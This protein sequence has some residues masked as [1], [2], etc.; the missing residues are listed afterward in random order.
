MTTTAD[1]PTTTARY[2]YISAGLLGVVVFLFGFGA[3]QWWHHEH[4]F[5]YGNLIGMPTGVGETIA[6]G[7]GGPTREI[8]IERAE[9]HLA[10]GSALATIEVVVCTH[11]P[12]SGVGSMRYEEIG[13]YCS[14]LVPAED[15]TLRP[16]NPQAYEDL[17]LLVTPLETGTVLVDGVDVHYREGWRNHS[18][19]TGVD[20]EVHAS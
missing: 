10:E 19:R 8:H 9:A 1:A 3:Y 17:V 7:M 20:A 18:E 16:Y 15:T 2:G 14:A 5:A 6:L 13:G 11:G 4:A 12:T